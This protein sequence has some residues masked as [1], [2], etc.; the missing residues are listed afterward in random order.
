MNLNLVEAI[1]SHE[2][3]YFGIFSST[4][5]CQFTDIALF[6]TREDSKRFLEFSE[7]RRRDRKLLRYSIVL[8]EEI[9]GTICLYSIY[10]HQRRAS[11][12]YALAERYWNKGIMSAALKQV[13]VISKDDWD[14]NRLQA[15]VIPDNSSS[16]T[17]LEKNGFVREGLLRQYEYWEGKGYVDLEMYGK[18]L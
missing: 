12:G 16:K 2:K 18:I 8:E 14:L 4:K 15:T 1:A 13:E 7:E 3:A 6:Q 5:V 10:W 17:V 9:V 11:I